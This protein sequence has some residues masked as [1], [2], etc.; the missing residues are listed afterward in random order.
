MAI[1]VFCKAGLVM[2]V[3]TVMRFFT[4]MDCACSDGDAVLYGARLLVRV[5]LVLGVYEYL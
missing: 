2:L 4:R 3:A 5:L 1:A